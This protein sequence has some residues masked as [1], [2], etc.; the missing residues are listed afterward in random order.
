MQINKRET[1]QLDTTGKLMGGTLADPQVKHVPVIP[2]HCGGH[3]SPGKLKHPLCAGENHTVLN[4]VINIKDES[5]ILIG[6]RKYIF[7][8]TSINDQRPKANRAYK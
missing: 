8:Q 4:N 5:K 6:N 2:S 3:M 1:R 7:W